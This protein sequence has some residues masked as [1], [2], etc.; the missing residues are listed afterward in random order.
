MYSQTLDSHALF[1]QQ[2]GVFSCMWPISG[3]EHQWYYEW[4]VQDF[5]SQEFS[6]LCKLWLTGSLLKCSHLWH[7]EQQLCNSPRRLKTQVWLYLKLLE[8]FPD[9][10]LS[11]EACCCL[12]SENLVI[13]KLSGTLITNREVLWL[14]FVWRFSVFLFFNSANI[15]GF[16][17]FFGSAGIGILQDGNALVVTFPLC[18][19]EHWFVS[20]VCVS[21][22]CG[23]GP[24]G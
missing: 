24:V 16:M 5:S 7:R 3:L 18:S 19:Y 4:L 2:G 23:G 9:T 13:Q 22:V 6:P 17:L 21:R 12:V 15:H 8:Y 14:S 20:C 10:R 11:A 1:F